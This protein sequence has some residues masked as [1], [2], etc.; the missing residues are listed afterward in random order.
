VYFVGV[1]PF[2]ST[3]L[4]AEV[5][6]G[7]FRIARRFCKGSTALV[8]DNRGEW[9]NLM[10]GMANGGTEIVCPVCH[11]FRRYDLDEILRTVEGLGAM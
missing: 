2:G 3:G 10:D 4:V 6:F 9:N 8:T 11:S 1:R 7:S 5:V